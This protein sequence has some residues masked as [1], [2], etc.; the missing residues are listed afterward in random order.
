MKSRTAR[1]AART[2]LALLGLAL[3]YPVVGYTSWLVPAN[4]DWREAAAGARVFV[5]TN[6]VHTG[7][8]M[9]LVH[10]LWD[11]RARLGMTAP[12]GTWVWIG[13]GQRDF[14][15]ETPRWADLRLRT[16]L[17]AALGSER[18]LVHVDFMTAPV[19]ES[20]A[21]PLVLRPSE[22]RRLAGAVAA[23]LAPGATPM[24]GYGPDDRFYE[25][26]GRYSAFATCNAWTGWMLRAAGVRV[27]RWTPT[28]GTVMMGF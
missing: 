11:W 10:P 19:P 21:R 16:A 13:W 5:M 17:A 22:Y 12:P 25:A 18:T 24:L 20:D 7:I 28:S 9:P 1:K 26:R 27:G 4:P 3:L 6:G 15:L 23:T 2:A 14:Y 8:A